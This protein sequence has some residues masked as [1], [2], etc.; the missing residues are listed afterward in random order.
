MDMKGSGL[1]D[2]SFRLRP[3]Y[4]RG[5]VQLMHIRTG[6]PGG[7]VLWGPRMLDL[8]EYICCNLIIQAG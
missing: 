5:V 8:L 4:P 6:R 7:R 2:W 1:E 3:N